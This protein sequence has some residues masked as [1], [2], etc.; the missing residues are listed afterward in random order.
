LRKGVEKT[1][2]EGGDLSDYLKARATSAPKLRLN[3]CYSLKCRAPQEPAL[4][5][6]DYVPLTPKWAGPPLSAS[7]NN[8]SG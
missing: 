6:A 4:G 5:M 8:G 1:V 3:E 7:K 2:A